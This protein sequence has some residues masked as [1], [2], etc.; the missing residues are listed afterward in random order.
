M[1]ANQWDDRRAE[2]EAKRAERGA[3]EEALEEMKRLL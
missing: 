1:V 2:E 3:E